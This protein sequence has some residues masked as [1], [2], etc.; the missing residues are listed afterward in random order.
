MRSGCSMSEPPLYPAMQPRGPD[1]HSSRGAYRPWLAARYPVCASPM[2]RRSPI[3]DD[4]LM[5][6]VARSMAWSARVWAPA[7]P[8][9]RSRIVPANAGRRPLPELLLASQNTGKL[10]EMRI[11]LEGLPCRV[12]RP[13]EL[14]ISEA[15][16]ETGST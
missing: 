15:P 5:M 10:A 11:L 16:E 1:R 12:V 6:R 13:A 14:G 3:V 4:S 8:R 2:A 9:A 7:E